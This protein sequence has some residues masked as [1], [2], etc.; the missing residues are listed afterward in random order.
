MLYK[1]FKG[2]WGL[3]VGGGGAARLTCISDDLSCLNVL[4]LLYQI[5]RVVGVVGFEAV[6]MYD[7]YEVAVA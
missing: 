6:G 2:N 5:L 4:T 1:W 3:E 7:A